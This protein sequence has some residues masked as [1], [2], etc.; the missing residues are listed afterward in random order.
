MPVNDPPLTLHAHPLSSYCWKVLLALYETET[1]FEQVSIAGSPKSDATLCSHWPI[2]KMPLLVDAARNQAVP[3]SSIII[4][5]LQQYYPNKTTLIPSAPAAM[6][7]TRLWDRF[8]DLHVHACVQKLVGDRLRPQQQR[9]ATGVAESTTAFDT[10]YA[11]LEQRMATRQFVAG[12]FS[13][14]DCAAMPALF[15]AEAVHPFSP[16]HPALAAYFERL[17]AR[18]SSRQ[19]IRA[20]QP[21]FQYFP[22]HSSLHP[23]FQNPDF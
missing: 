11:M 9:D 5:Y 8:F 15:Y 22:F 19:I 4:E 1:P 16:S 10:A 12:E 21:Y 14:A 13:M 7:D 23:R 20:A 6:L 2:G 17:V 3:E 18:Q